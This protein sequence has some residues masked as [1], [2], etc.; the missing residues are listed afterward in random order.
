MRRKTGPARP[1]AIRRNGA[2]LTTFRALARAGAV[3]CLLLA[4]LELSVLV[5]EYPGYTRP[6]FRWL[7]IE[8]LPLLLVGVINIAA[9]DAPAGGSRWAGFLAVAVDLALLLHSLQAVTAGAAPLTF[10]LA[11]V[12]ALLVMGT[13]GMVLSRS[14]VRF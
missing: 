8:V 12:A 5:D 14:Y 9:L 4:A 6:A 13:V 7:A 1:V 3:F 2:L 11:G 10:M